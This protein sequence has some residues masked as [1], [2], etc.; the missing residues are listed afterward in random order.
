MARKRMIHAINDALFEEM[1]RDERVIL[2]GEDVGTSIFGD[3]RGLQQRFGRDRVRDTPISETVMAGMAIGAAA[4]G[5]RVVCHLMYANFIYTAFDAI[6]NQATKL[7]LMTNGQIRLPIVFMA[8]GGGGRSNSA[9]HSDYPHAALAS[10]GGLY[11]VTP[12]NSADA[13]GLLKSAIRCDDPVVFLQPASRGGEM[14]DVPD[15]E[16]LIPLGQASVAKEGADVTLVA[17]AAMLRPALR[18]AADLGEEGIDVEVVN[19]RTVFPLDRG[20]ILA[21]LKKTG[22]LVVADEARSA[23]SMANQIASVAVREGFGL[24]KAPMISITTRDL[25]IAYSPPLEQAMIPDADRISSEI[26]NLM[27]ERGA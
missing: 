27:R 14:G 7:R 23:G 20:T 1:E 19:M 12:G 9:Q 3:T 26:R 22:R 25:P 11:V 16:T 15:E 13:K 4:A 24:L 17:V 18:A 2:F 21:S 6:A 8:V 10:L 5:Y